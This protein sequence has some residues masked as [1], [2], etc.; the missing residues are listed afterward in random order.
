MLLSDGLY[1]RLPKIWILIGVGFLV[2]GLAAGPQLT[3][4]WGMMAL[5]VL[6]ILRGMQI[7]QSR[8]SILK[9]TQVMVLTKT[10][11]MENRQ[12]AMPREDSA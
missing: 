1:H 2:V 3:Y 8:K 7:N 12:N 5:G 11:K 10:Q 4:F 9:K 6:C